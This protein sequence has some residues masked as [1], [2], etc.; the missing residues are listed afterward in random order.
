MKLCAHA[1]DIEELAL[2]VLP[3][4]RAARAEAH[5][6]GCPECSAE[7]VWLRQERKLFIR[8]ARV[9]PAMPLDIEDV[10]AR[11]GTE[12]RVARRPRNPLSGR[13]AAALA[14]LAAAAVVVLVAR[15][16]NVVPWSAFVLR[17]G[18]AAMVEQDEELSESE[19]VACNRSACLQTSL[20]ASA[21]EPMTCWQP[22]ALAS[23]LQNASCS[24]INP[25]DWDDA[26]CEPDPLGNP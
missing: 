20:F 22:A 1:T 21:C 26:R 16:W 4:D 17:G 10:F 15:A 7:L 6:S 18:T 23:R 14:A 24:Q 3:P 5:A 12:R 19:P 9:A 8:R 25:L 11:L 13:V 2:G